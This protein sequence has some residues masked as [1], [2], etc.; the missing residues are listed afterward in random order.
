MV[1][2]FLQS[3]EGEGTIR[4]KNQGWYRCHYVQ[5]FVRRTKLQNILFMSNFMNCE[6]KIIMFIV[7]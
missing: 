1:V 3:K 5:V 7:S 2:P 6:G 4:D